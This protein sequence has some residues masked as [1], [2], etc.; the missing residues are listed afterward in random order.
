MRGI[1]R[2]W[3]L[4]LSVV[5]LLTSCS[6]SETSI[7]LSDGLNSIELVS[8]ANNGVSGIDVEVF[9]NVIGDDG[10]DYTNE[11]KLYLNGNLIEENPYVFT[12]I[13]TFEIT[14]ELEELRSNTLNLRVIDQI[15]REL[16]LNELRLMPNQEVI[17]SLIDYLGEDTSEEATFYINGNAIAGNSFQSTE[18]GTYEVYAT[19]EV[20]SEIINTEVKE[21]SIYIARRHLMLEDYTGTWCGY[22]PGVIE[23]IDGVVDET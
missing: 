14:A 6:K 16:V 18:P 20:D 11:S 7:N 17:F 3:L 4:S 10:G 2:I 8:T 1:T 15:S 9:F 12:E 23:A 13:G 5:A 19:Y 22:C 21:F